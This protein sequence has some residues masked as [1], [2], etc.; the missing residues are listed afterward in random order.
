[1]RRT[2]A[3]LGAPEQPLI[4]RFTRSWWLALIVLSAGLLAWVS[5]GYVGLHARQRR[6]TAW[7]ILYLLLAVGSLSLLLVGGSS[8]STVAAVLGTLVLLGVWVGSV[9][10]GLLIRGE[11]LTRGPY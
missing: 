8:N 9:V 6:W 10:H 7:G 2:P 5:F 11:A 4:W 3:R 1:M